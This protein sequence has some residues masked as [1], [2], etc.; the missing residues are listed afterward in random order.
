[1]SYAN[2]MRLAATE[3]EGILAQ[4]GGAE[5]G[6][7]TFIGPDGRSYSGV[8]RAASVFESQAVGS[9]MESHGFKDAEVMVVSATRTQFNAPPLGWR[10]QYLN[11]LKPAQKCLVAS[12][13][14]SDS[15]LYAFVLIYRQGSA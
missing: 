3:A 2:L 12:I 6:V 1:M 5:P 14:V 8:F 15:L 7:D 9:E 10:R 11:R 4:L 13:S